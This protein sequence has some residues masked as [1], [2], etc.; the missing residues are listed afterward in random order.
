MQGLDIIKEQFCKE[1]PE[2]FVKFFSERIIEYPKII[3]DELLHYRSQQITY[4]RKDLVSNKSTYKY[5]I[6]C[7]DHFSKFYWGF[8]I[9]NK[10]SETTLNKIKIFFEF[11]KK[12]II[13]HTDNEL[14]FVNKLLYE[15]LNNENVKTVQSKPYYPQTNGC[16]ERIHREVKKY[17]KKYLEKTKKILLMKIWKMV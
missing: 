10:T 3:I 17:L 4:L 1:C 9:R 16:I 14:E 13:L 11:N 8:L 5:I 6:D 2:C 12:A 7:I 15:Y